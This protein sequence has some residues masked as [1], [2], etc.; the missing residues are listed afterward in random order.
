MQSL[1]REEDI[2]AR[3][4]GDEFAIVLVNIAPSKE[5]AKEYAVKKCHAL[6]ARLSEAFFIEGNEIYIGASIGIKIFPDNNSNI[7][8][9]IND[10]DKA[11]YTSKRQGKNSCSLACE[12]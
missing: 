8:N 3:I 12:I 10:A 7:E 6:I 11:M 9:I 4:S 1:L 2:L 5:E